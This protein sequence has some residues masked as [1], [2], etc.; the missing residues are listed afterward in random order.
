MRKDVQLT[1]H[2]K[3]CDGRGPEVPPLRR[4]LK[5]KSTFTVSASHEPYELGVTITNHFQVRYK[6]AQGK[7]GK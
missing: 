7:E 6:E 5:F 2:S 1:H 3:S 4:H